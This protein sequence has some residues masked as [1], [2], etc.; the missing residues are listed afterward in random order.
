MDA[1]TH[2]LSYDPDEIWK[3]MMIAY[4][5]AGGDILYP[6]DEKEML[7]RGVL[8]IVVQVFAA[9]DAAL[10]MDTLRYAVGQYLDIYGEK[11]GCTRNAAEAATCDVR[12][13]LKAGFT[14]TIPAGTAL[15]ADGEKLYLLCEDVAGSGIAQTVTAQIVCRD[16]GRAGNGLVAGTQMQMLCDTPYVERIV[17]ARDASGGQDEETDEAYRA[18][19][20]TYGLLNTTTGPQKQYQ[21]AAM[22]VSSEILDARALNLGAGRVGVYLLVEDGEGAEAIVRSV[23]DALSAWD[24]R[25]LTDEVQVLLS[26]A[27]PY[28][29]NVQ[30]TCEAGTSIDEAAALEVREY[31]AWQDETIGRAFN[32]DKL[33]AMLYQAGATRVVWGEGS[34][35]DGGAVTY[36]PIAPGA[37]CKGT[38]RLEVAADDR[39]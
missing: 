21:A 7:L 36:T 10:R 17:T 19:I 12:I 8:A 20:R 31:Q 25:P 11:R 33:M 30:A 1:E 24:A 34:S 38:I 3:E 27:V 22:A 2:Y 6:G 18:R 9:V 29:L 4:V 35:F 39:I 5:E 26:D 32:P 15:T 23:Q 16:A 37:H 14:R 28:E 13:S